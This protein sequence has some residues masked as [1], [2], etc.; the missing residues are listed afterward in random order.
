MTNYEKLKEI[1]NTIDMAQFINTFPQF[2]YMDKCI[3]DCQNNVKCT[4]CIDDFLKK[5]YDCKCPLCKNKM[6]ISEDN[7]TGICTNRK[8]TLSFGYMV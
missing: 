5:E 7:K 3:I 4:V 8:C 6:I 1:N 2:G